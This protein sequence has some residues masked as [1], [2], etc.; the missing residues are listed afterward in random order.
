MIPHLK[1]KEFTVSKIDWACVVFYY[2]AGPVVLG[3]YCWLVYAL[4]S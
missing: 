4:M 3:M 2:S 1:I